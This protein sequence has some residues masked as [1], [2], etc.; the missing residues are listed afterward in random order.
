MKIIIR[1]RD[2]GK[3]Q[4]LLKYAQEN[5]ALVITSNKRGLKTKAKELNIR[6]VEII[7][8]NDLENDNFDITKPVIIHN[9]DKFLQTFL[10]HYF[11]IQLIG[12]SATLDETS[13]G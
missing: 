6:N 8:Y 11:N 12:M 10:E 9:A 1:S 7:D 3:A 5:N 4:E 2:S 13:V